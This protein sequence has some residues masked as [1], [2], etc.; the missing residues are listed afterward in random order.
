MLATRQGARIADRKELRMMLQCTQG[1]R[2]PASAC[3]PRNLAG[4]HEEK[5]AGW[6]R[7]AI[8]HAIASAWYTGKQRKDKKKIFKGREVR[9]A[10]CTLSVGF[11]MSCLT[12]SICVQ[13]SFKYVFP[14]LFQTKINAKSQM[15]FHGK[16]RS[17]GM[18]GFLQSFLVMPAAAP[19]PGMGLREQRWKQN[20]ERQV[21]LAAGH[22]GERGRVLPWQMRLWGSVSKRADGVQHMC[23]MVTFQVQRLQ[24]LLQVT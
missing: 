14:T 18:Q 16:K 9:A 1:R 4:R 23:L 3:P 12:E 7:S 13:L 10:S 5:G 8:W 6:N 11:L 24:E 15:I 21:L 20:R 2:K 19:D 17:P 22:T